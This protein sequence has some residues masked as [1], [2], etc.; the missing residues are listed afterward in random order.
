MPKL[1]A[2]LGYATLNSRVGLNCG[3]TS[4]TI[5]AAVNAAL[6]WARAFAL[7]LAQVC[8]SS[9][10]AAG[11]AAAEAEARKV[12]SDRSCMVLI[13][14]LLASQDVFVLKDADCNTM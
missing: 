1:T 12:K 5:F 13:G 3:I 6:A 2:L 11:M 8:L 10:V 9:R 7:A 4:G 14:L